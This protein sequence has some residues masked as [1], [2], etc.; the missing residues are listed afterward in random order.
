MGPNK[1]AGGMRLEYL[2]GYRSCG[3]VRIPRMM[4]VAWRCLALQATTGS[5]RQRL[6]RFRVHFIRNLRI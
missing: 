2:P 1:S 5:R 6:I 3:R 4:V